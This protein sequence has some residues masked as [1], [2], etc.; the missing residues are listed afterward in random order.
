MKITVNQF[1]GEVPR[2]TPRQLPA[3]NA[4]T[5]QKTLLERGDLT[6][7]RQLTTAYTFQSAQQTFVRHEN[8]WY[9]WDDADV[10]FAPG[11][12]DE[13]RLYFTGDG[14]PKLRYIGENYALA[15]AAPPVA[16]QL[17]ITNAPADPVPNDPQDPFASVPTAGGLVATKLKILRQPEGS[18]SRYQ[19]LTQPGL[20][21]VDAD[22]L[23]CDADNTTQVYVAVYDGYG[24]LIEGT[25]TV[26]ASG[27]IIRFTD[28]VFTGDH[29]QDY[30]LI[31]SVVDNEDRE[32]PLEEET[33]TSEAF[34]VTENLEDLTSTVLYAYTYVTSL[35]EESAPSP[36][37]EPLDW[38]PS[39]IVR[40]G[41]FSAAPAGRLIDKIRVYR[42]QTSASG[43]TDLYFV[44]EIPLAQA[45]FDHD[46]EEDPLGEVLP[47]AD[48]DTPPDDMLGITSMPNG[49]MAGFS[50]RTVCFC[51]PYRPHAWPTKYRLTI[52]TDIVALA[53]FGSVLAVLTKGTP[54]VA[55]G[56][57]PETMSMER[58][59]TYAPCLAAKGVVDLGYAAAFP[60]NDGLAVI[61]PS[62]CDIATR[63]LFTREQWRALNPSTFIAS[64][65][66]GRYIF[67]HNAAPAGQPSDFTVDAIAFSQEG[68]A[69]FV[70]LDMA[71]IA[72]FYDV[73]SGA[74]YFLDPDGVSVKQFENYAA[75]KETFVWRSGI[76]STLTE[77]NFGA[78]YI[79][80]D[81]DPS[82]T[83]TMRFYGDGVLRHTTTQ[84]NAVGRLPSGYL[85]REWEIEI[86]GN[87]TVY[88]VTIAATIEGLMDA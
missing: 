88:A 84:V 12:V 16:P 55:Q 26:T 23:L 44:K 70:Q 21:I 52:D 14:A 47:S 31:F 39:L 7:V 87:T 79:N 41:N 33:I 6:P 82:A 80:A 45:T 3:G 1:R 2:V 46:L 62:S 22:G 19:M 75:N 36:L 81:P 42:S 63:A 64:A 40:V 29:E 53:A 38:Y 67:R 9:G 65:F 27:G 11:P 56:L 34:Q 74:L 50:G 69:D 35:G 68:Q 66:G 30:S 32:T 85:C 51:E 78:F 18:R 49:M 54:Y 76:I 20:A 48:Y 71:A 83:V 8:A 86:E 60:S 58:M 59:E 4:Q 13:D 15:L 43:V 24:G 5:A 17:T 57:H 37:T 77:F 28:L 72:M 73:P 10:Q 61:T 25:R